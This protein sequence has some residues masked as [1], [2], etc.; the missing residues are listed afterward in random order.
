L[1]TPSIRRPTPP[2]GLDPRG[3][4]VPNYNPKMFLQT[5]FILSVYVFLR[6]GA[7]VPNY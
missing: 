1:P 6:G 2:P 3:E 5:C 4:D 7:S